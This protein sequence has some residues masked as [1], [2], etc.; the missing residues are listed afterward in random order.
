MLQVK[1]RVAVL[2]LSKIIKISK[3]KCINFPNLTFQRDLWKDNLFFVIGEAPEGIDPDM[4]HSSMFRSSVLL[5]K[6]YQKSFAPRKFGFLL[7]SS[8]C[9]LPHF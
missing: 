9:K 5:A 1:N 2:R 7:K 4:I 8:I 6:F 3:K